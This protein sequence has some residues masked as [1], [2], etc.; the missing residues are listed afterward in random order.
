MTDRE[1][2]VLDAL[3]AVDFPG[4]DVL[5]RQIPSALVARTCVCGC[6][7]IDFAHPPA[8]PNV[9]VVANAKVSGSA[10]ELFLF[11]SDGW[12]GGIEWVGYSAEKPEALPAP[13]LLQIWSPT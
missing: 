5:R 8:G 10:D 11:T 12:L 1:R 7:S 13:E 6:P 4:A 3:L 2:A 9:H